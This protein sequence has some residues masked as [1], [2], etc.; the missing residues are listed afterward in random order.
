MTD[1]LHARGRTIWSP[2]RTLRAPGRG[3][4]SDPES[5]AASPIGIGDGTTSIGHTRW[6]THGGP[7]DRN[8]H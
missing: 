3:D 1:D 4:A 8:A 6:A 7:T 5:C 2:G